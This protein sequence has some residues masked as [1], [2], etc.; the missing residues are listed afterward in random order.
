MF[1]PSAEAVDRISSEL[2]ALCEAKGYHSTS[3]FRGQLKVFNKTAAAEGRGRERSDARGRSNVGSIAGGVGSTPAGETTGLSL[4]TLLYC[5]V[6]CLSS[7]VVAL[8]AE[9]QGVIGGLPARASLSDFLPP[10]VRFKDRR[11]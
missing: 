3:E 10:G 5:I 11:L 7:V 4:C 2:A 1:A 6:A 9:R 8:I